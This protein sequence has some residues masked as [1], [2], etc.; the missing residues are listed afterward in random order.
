MRLLAPLVML[1][2]V[3]VPSWSAANTPEE[4]AAFQDYQAQR[5]ELVSKKGL[6]AAH[7]WQQLATHPHAQRLL[8]VSAWC[9]Q[10]AAVAFLRANDEASACTEAEAALAIAGDSSE[11]RKSHARAHAIIGY[12]CSTRA[13]TLDLALQHYEAAVSLD[14]SYGNAK[15]GLENV[16]AAIAKNG[17]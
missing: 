7:G 12:F 10:N 16:K 1:L 4:F 8:Y 5:A 2:A 14:P 11:L 17:G 13:S 6:Q 15:V 3:L 9:H